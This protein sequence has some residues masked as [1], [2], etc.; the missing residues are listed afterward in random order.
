MLTIE[1]ILEVVKKLI[2]VA[3]KYDPEMVFAIVLQMYAGL[4]SAEVC[5]LRQE[6]SVFGPSVRLA[7]AGGDIQ[8][9]TGITIDLLHDHPLRSDAKST[10]WIKTKRI[11]EVFAENIPI[12]ETAYKQHLALI[13][14]KPVETSRPLFL[15]RYPDKKTGAYMA[16]TVRGYRSRV[17]RLYYDHVLPACREDANPIL[18]KYFR[19]TQVTPWGPRNLRQWY[20]LTS[21]TK[22]TR[23]EDLV[24]YSINKDL[25]LQY[26]SDVGNREGEKNGK[27][28]YRGTQCT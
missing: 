17:K 15:C 19:E 10:G 12:I 14:S 23:K 16:L 20:L 26:Y 18:R 28:T 22:T 9:C 24:R 8:D 7:H 6:D 25:R 5:S 11:H 4:R 27:D 3:E 1:M 21:I 13:R 2:S